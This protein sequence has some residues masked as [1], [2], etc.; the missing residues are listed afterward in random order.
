[1]KRVFIVLLTVF[2]AA[3]FMVGCSQSGKGGTAAVK[4]ERLQENHLP[5]KIKD[6]IE[7]I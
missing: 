4:F 2:V 3:V 1:M 5:Q 6:S 7:S